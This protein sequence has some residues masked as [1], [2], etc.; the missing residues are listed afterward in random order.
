MRLLIFNIR[1]GVERERGILKIRKQW[2]VEKC[3]ISDVLLGTFLG[4]ESW[5]SNDCGGLAN[6]KLSWSQLGSI[7]QQISRTR[8]LSFVVSISIKTRV[9][10]DFSWPLTSYVGGGNS[11]N[12]LASWGQMQEVRRWRSL[13]VIHWSSQ[14]SKGLTVA[15][16]QTPGTR[17]GGQIFGLWLR[18]RTNYSCC[19]TE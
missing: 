19:L 4:S 16:R 8:P 1:A 17:G 18:R 13:K 5:W 12:F 14:R 3:Q 9:L 7:T 15:A 2:P 11:S 6:G 10:I